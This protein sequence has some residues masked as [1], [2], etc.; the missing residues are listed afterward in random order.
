MTESTSRAVFRERITGPRWMVVAGII[1][2]ALLIFVMWLAIPELTAAPE[3]VNGG[4]VALLFVSTVM[5][6]IAVVLLITR[7]ST[8]V[9]TETHVDAHLDPFR[10]MHIPLDAIEAVDVVHADFS[11]SRGW[12]W[13]LVGTE[14]YLMWSGGPAVRLT[15][16]KGRSRV[17]RSDRAGEMVGAIASVR[18]DPGHR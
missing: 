4:L 11:D 14:Q 15:L 3:K 2:L 7:R 6:V 5:V 8:I 12:G 16:T 10:I 17:L 1:T 18:S 13:R 9:I